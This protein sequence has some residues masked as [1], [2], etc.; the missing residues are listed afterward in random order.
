M[1]SSNKSDLATRSVSAAAWNYLGTIVRAVLQFVTQI[2]LARLLGQEAFG[3]VTAA[4]TILFLYALIIEL[5]LG[6]ALVQ[7][8]VVD[9]ATIQFV[10]TR[11]LAAATTGAVIIASCSEIVASFF[12]EPDTSLVLRFMAI[13]FF[14]QGLGIV[15]LSLLRRELQH[16]AVQQAQLSGYILGFVVVGITSAVAGAGVWS[17]VAAWLVQNIVTTCLLYRRIRHS[18]KLRCS[19]AGVSLQRFG[20]KVM[21]TNLCNYLTENI[22]RFFVGRYFGTATLGAYSVSY[23]LVRTPTNNIVTSLQQVL[24]PAAARARDQIASIQ[25]AFLT[26]IWGVGLVTFAVFFSIASIGDIFI[27]GLLGNEWQEASKFVMPLALAMPFHALMAVCGPIL[28]GRGAVS[29]ELSVQFGSAIALVFVLFAASYSATAMAWGLFAVYVCRSL[30]ML[31]VI[32]RHLSLS[33]R[34]IAESVSP[35]LLVSL[36][37]A[38]SVWA[39][40]KISAPHV[41]SHSQQL[42]IGTAAGAISWPTAFWAMGSRILPDTLVPALQEFRLRRGARVQQVT[43]RFFK[44]SKGMGK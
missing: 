31:A 4:L 19:P 35:A 12:A 20:M 21:A 36:V 33:K 38:A 23:N 22:D 40:V 13:A 30:V 44:S 5:G 1:P 3:I 42:L 10:Y 2:A 18:V 34:Q 25:I 16:K 17:L 28:W 26:S 39:A 41:S 9:D 43:S 32:K 14:I 8:A 7:T 37:V 15:S 29:S 6:S 27:V 11:I 24:F